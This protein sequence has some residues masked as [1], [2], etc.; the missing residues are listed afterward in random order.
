MP[1]QGPQALSRMRAPAA[2]MVASAPFWASMVSTWRE[3][4]E[5]TRLTFSATVCPLRISA[6]FIMSANEEL[7]QLP[8]H[9]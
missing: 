1:M 7:V 3:P 8:M 2:T 4:G 6:T 9:T 5:M